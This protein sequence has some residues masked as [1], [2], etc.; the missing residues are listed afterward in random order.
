MDLRSFT[1]R[2]ATAYAPWYVGG[3]LALAATN[4]LSVRIPVEVARAVDALGTPQASTI[5]PH[6]AVLIGV[7]GAM[8]VGVRTLSRVAFFDPGRHIESQV[9]HDLFA[10]LLRQQPAF[11]RKHAPGDLVSRASSDL[12][13]IRLLYGFGV[14][15][16]V[17]TVLA[18]SLAG[19]QMVRISPIL[20]AWTL[21]PIVFALVVTQL[22]IRRLYG[23]LHRIQ[24]EIA[25]ISD[26][27]LSSYQ[28]VATVQAFGAESAFVAR[29]DAKND[30]YLRTSLQRAT[31]RTVLGPALA[32]AAS[33]N[34]FAVL[35]VGAPLTRTGVLSV[36]DLVAWGSLVGLL[37]NPLR[38][39]SFVAQIWKQA[40]VAVERLG[41]VM[42][43]EP[44]RPDLPDPKPAPDHPPA[45][46][47]RGLSFAYPDQPDALVL[48]DV[49][50]RIDS[51]QTLGVL[52]ATGSGKTTLLRCVSRLF[53][54][55]AGSVF[56]NGVDVRT[57]DLDAWRERMVMV[58]QRAFLFSESL[59]DNVLM[60][61]PDE[62][63]LDRMLQLTTLDVDVQQLP[64]GTATPVGE[65]GIMLSGGQ[66]QRVA[67]ARGLLR[68][69]Q[70]VLILDDVLS[71]V[72]H[73]TEHALLETIRGAARRPTTILVSHR[74]SAIQDAALIIVL[75]GGRVVDHGTHDELVRR[76]GFYRETWE[77]Q[78]EG[79]ES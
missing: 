17:N 74:I 1:R 15:Q 41:E 24:S 72:D 58:P 38:G 12:G 29:F 63:R 22:S 64:Q 67:I 10:R 66:R 21:V 76:P 5:V 31:L 33:L 50:F 52:G 53:N 62:G 3:C 23:I 42:D 65:T 39:V 18:V 2:Y 73:A 60:G 57:M 25:A 36:G 51:G 54:P 48:D 56:V 19:A 79:K 77:R 49:S 46:E 9:K 40:Q 27:V 71:A 4:G 28:G 34:V 61:L 7:M 37:V 45:I 6:Q 26:H 47:V 70:Q 78:S 11:M 55:P 69:A 30:A 16:A 20:A 8:V 68:P 14:L 44:E 59:G 35:W 32:L 43:P 75:D 13:N